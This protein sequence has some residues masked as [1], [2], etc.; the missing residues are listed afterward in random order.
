MEGGMERNLEGTI[1]M[2]KEFGKI[3]K[4]LNMRTLFQLF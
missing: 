4:E 2:S 3:W 1:W